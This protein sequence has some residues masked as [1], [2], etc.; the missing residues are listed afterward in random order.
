[1]QPRLYGEAA[2]ENVG[3]KLIE[4]FRGEAVLA[5]VDVESAA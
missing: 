5:P 3:R 1:V 2:A 4:M